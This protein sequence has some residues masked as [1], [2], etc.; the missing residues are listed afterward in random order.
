MKLPYC[1]WT[2]K[3]S[4]RTGLSFHLNQEIVR[5]CR[6]FIQQPVKT[7][8]YRSCALTFP[9]GERVIASAF[10]RDSTLDLLLPVGAQVFH[11]LSIKLQFSDFNSASFRAL[12]RFADH[13]LLSPLA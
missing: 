3:P 9:T 12:L 7:N 8:N 2:R 11:C 13:R 4:S 5:V 6:G 1:P 10:C